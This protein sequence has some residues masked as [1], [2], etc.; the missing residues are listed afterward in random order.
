VNE[1]LFILRN[2]NGAIDQRYLFYSVLQPET[3]AK[4]SR[5][6][7][8]S[9]Q[10]GLNSTFVN[11][12]EILVPQEAN[13][14]CR[15]AEILSTV[16]E[17]IEQTEAQIAKYQQIKAGM[18]HDLF[19]RGVKPDGKL[20]SAYTEA[21]HL[22]K[23]SPLGWIPK[24]WEVNVLRYYVPRV[25]YGV[26]IG[27]DEKPT[28]IPVLRMN[29]IE[30]GR[31]IVTDIK[32]AGATQVKSLLLKKGD[33]LFNR[34][35]SYEHVGKTAIWNDEL[36]IASFASYLVRLDVDLQKMKG[37]FLTQWLNLPTTQLAIRR[38]ATPGVHQ[39]NINPTNL[40]RMVCSAPKD[41]AE[42]D[43]IT[44]RVSQLETVLLKN[45]ERLDKLHQQKQ[46]LMH[47]LLTGKVRVKVE[48]TL[49]VT[50]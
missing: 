10:P 18:M 26:S 21:P 7:T 3:Q 14:Q 19:T 37:L 25:A 44:E 15:I 40:R 28:G 41:I 8:G 43:L 17:A 20:R 6:I 32:F 39:V 11:S 48:A 47:D 9:A 23:D 2:I 46:G 13:V 50:N 29:N 42:Q 34:T 1:H 35:N 30:Q 38:F 33:I 27:M 5:R 16:D 36:P 24:E 31:I 45:E 12:V 49:S 22:Y 4:I